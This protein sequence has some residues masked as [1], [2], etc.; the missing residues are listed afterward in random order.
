MTFRGDSGECG[1]P[2]RDNGRLSLSAG[3][4]LLVRFNG[5]HLSFDEPWYEDHL[6]HLAFGTHSSTGMFGHPPD[7]VLDRRVDLW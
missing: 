2:R 5:R 4:H 1:Q 3:Q 7:L 6:I